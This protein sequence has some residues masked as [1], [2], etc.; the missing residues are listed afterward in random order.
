MI[1]TSELNSIIQARKRIAN[2]PVE[3]NSLYRTNNKRILST[4][5]IIEIRSY[6]NLE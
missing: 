2:I 1:E 6:A 3:S 5:R 4:I